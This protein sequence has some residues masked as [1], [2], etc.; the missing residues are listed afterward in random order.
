MADSGRRGARVRGPRLATLLLATVIFGGTL[1]Y[2]VIEGWSAWDAFYMTIITVTTVGYSE[3]HDLSFAGEA[4][5]VVL[6]MS[7]V[8]AALYTFTLVATVVVEGGSRDVCS[9]DD[10]RP[11]LKRSPTT[12]SCADTGESVR[13]SL[14]SSDV[15][16][17]PWL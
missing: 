12:S 14:A 10:V 16:V 17:F 15:K 9:F 7:G 8:G 1:G 2:V 4:F 13:P 3:V 5:T 11:C 6:A